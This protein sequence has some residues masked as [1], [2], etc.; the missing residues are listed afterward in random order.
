MDFRSIRIGSNTQCRQ[1]FPLHLLILER[2][3]NNVILI[4]I[5]WK[6]AYGKDALSPQLTERVQAVGSEARLHD[7][8]RLIARRARRLEQADQL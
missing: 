8:N 3:G 5:V 6:P 7:K 4:K 2:M 1:Q